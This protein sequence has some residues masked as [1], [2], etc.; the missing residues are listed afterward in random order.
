MEGLELAPVYDTYFSPLKD[1]HQYWF[2]AML[3]VRGILLILLTI[4]SVDNPELSVFTLFLLIAFLLFF[5]SIENVYK[6]V[7]VRVLKSA[8]LFNLIVLSSGTLY[9]WESTESRSKLLMVSTGITFAQFCII[10]V[11]SLIKSCLQ[12]C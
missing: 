4:T 12:F 9:R 1:K 7:D 2:G 5:T 8:I 6:R 3:L 11:W 10:V